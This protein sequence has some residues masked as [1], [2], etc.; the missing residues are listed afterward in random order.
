MEEKCSFSL[1][2]FLYH[3]WYLLESQEKLHNIISNE[4]KTAYILTKCLPKL[5]P[6]S[7]QVCDH[8]LMAFPLIPMFLIDWSTL[9]LC[10]F[11]TL[12][13]IHCLVQGLPFLTWTIIE[14]VWLSPCPW[15]LLFFPVYLHFSLNIYPFPI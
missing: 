2:S 8:V 9:E 14:I 6:D 3:C 13:L 1:G 4:K 15:Y 12:L 10:L 5:I 11:L 7:K